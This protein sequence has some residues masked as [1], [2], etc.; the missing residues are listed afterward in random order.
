MI[1]PPEFR[2]N[3]PFEPFDMAAVPKSTMAPDVMI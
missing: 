2:L 1:F 3:V